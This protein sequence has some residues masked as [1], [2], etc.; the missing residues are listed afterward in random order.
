MNTVYIV[1]AVRTPIGRYSGALAGVRPDDLAT[2]AIRE[3]LPDALERVL[4]V[5]Q[6]QRDSVRLELSRI[7]RHHHA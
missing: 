6:V 2:H 1:D 4:R 5:R 3:L 7:H